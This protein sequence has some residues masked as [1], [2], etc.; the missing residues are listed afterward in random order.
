MLSLSLM[1]KEMQDKINTLEESGGGGSV[2]FDVSKIRTSTSYHDGQ[3]TVT[4]RYDTDGNIW[5]DFTLTNPIT[6]PK[7]F[8]AVIV[9]S[10]IHHVVDRISLS[11]SAMSIIS[12]TEKPNSCPVIITINGCSYIETSA[13]DCP[14]TVNRNSKQITWHSSIAG[15]AL[16]KKSLAPVIYVRYEVTDAVEK[17][18]ENIDITQIVNNSFSLSN[19]SA[20]RPNS[21]SVV[22]IINGVSYFEDNEEFVVNR[23]TNPATISWNQSKTG[24]ALDSGLTGYVTVLYEIDVT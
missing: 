12:L 14:F 18:R 13:S 15:I 7:Q 24:F 8:G 23:T 16:T 20:S 10:S 11:E 3:P 21:T 2:N 5:L 22:I 6:N 19:D 9:D 4:P 1:L 17:M